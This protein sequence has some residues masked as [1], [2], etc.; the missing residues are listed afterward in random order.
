[1][2]RVINFILFK[3]GIDPLFDDLPGHI[4]GLFSFLE[5][6]G[7]D[8]SSYLLQANLVIGA[9]LQVGR[10]EV[11]FGAVLRHTPLVNTSLVDEA[12][13]SDLARLLGLTVFND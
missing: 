4:E 1:M 11:D 7:C 13:S 2:L 5:L 10:W 3:D 6:I 8:P 12:E 9:E